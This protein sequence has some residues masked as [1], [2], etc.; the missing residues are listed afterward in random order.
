MAEIKGVLFDKDGTLFDFRAT[1]EQWTLRFLTDLAAGDGAKL[2]QLARSVKFDLDRTRFERDSQIIAGTPSDIAEALLPHLPGEGKE[3]FLMAMNRSTALAEMVPAAP[4]RPLLKGLLARGLT[5]GVATNDSE[6]PAR[7]HLRASGIE[8]H[9]D[10]IVGFDSGYGAKPTAGMCHGFCER[11]KLS[12]DQVV[13]VGDSRHDLLAG[14]A[15]GMRT[16]GVLTGMARESELQPL[17]DEVLPH[18]G[19]LPAWLETSS[20][21]AE[22]QEPA[23]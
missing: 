4:L 5:L 17:A 12:P 22:I 10:Y 7:A 3:G 20:Y 8:E 6:A 14:R 15:A 18:I 21:T 9:F 13:M 2:H 23:A 19:H 1:W 11:T 16:I